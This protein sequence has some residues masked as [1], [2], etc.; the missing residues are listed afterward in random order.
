MK[1]LILPL[2]SLFILFNFTDLSAQQ[3]R[4]SS[5]P[6]FD[7][8]VVSIESTQNNQYRYDRAIR[9]FLNGNGSVAELIEVCYYLPNDKQRFQLC[10]EAYPHLVDKQ[11][12]FRVYDSFS[13]FSWAIKLYHLTQAQDAAIVYEDPDYPPVT[14]P[15]IEFPS[16]NNYHGMIGTNCRIPMEENDFLYYFDRLRLDREEYR[17]L[18]F[19][20]QQVQTYCFTTAQVMKLGLEL[21]SDES[22]VDF[23][24]YAGNKV[25]DL[26]N[27]YASLQLIDDP[28]YRREL[29]GYLTG[30]ISTGNVV[31]VQAQDCRTSATDFRYIR[32]SIEDQSFSGEKKEMAK[33]HIRKAC[34]SIEQ[35][36]EIVLLFDFDNDRLEIIKYSYNYVNNPDKM[37]MLRECLKF[38]S[39][40]QELDKFLMGR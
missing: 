24:K 32:E 6:W 1:K 2:L 35:I 16:A 3:Q 10:S 39:N 36:K 40:K 15:V 19:L 14:K 37:Y 34:L 31:H 26:D 23:L 11:H 33:S 27:F 17:R 29:Q 28:Y 8:V 9:Y 38:Q 5:N 21:P 18:A 25:Y 30:H 13:K 7:R 12:F 20:K 4:R 22:Q